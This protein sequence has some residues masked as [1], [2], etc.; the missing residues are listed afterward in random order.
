[1]YKY[2]REIEILDQNYTFVEMVYIRIKL[3]KMFEY[4]CTE[5]DDFLHKGNAKFARLT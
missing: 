4:M 3:T 1:M 5:I 2:L